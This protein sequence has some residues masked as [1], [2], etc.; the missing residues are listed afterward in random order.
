M[1]ASSYWFI[2]LRE[3]GRRE[4]VSKQKRPI[5]WRLVENLRAAEYE[6]RCLQLR[7]GP[8]S[9]RPIV[10]PLVQFSRAIPPTEVERASNEC[11]GSTL[12]SRDSSKNNEAL[13]TRIILTPGKYLLLYET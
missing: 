5:S 2:Y 10:Q 11:M 8:R 12:T 9:L 13:R 7:R 1:S 3:M 4:P 6:R